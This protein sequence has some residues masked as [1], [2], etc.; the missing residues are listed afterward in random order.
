MNHIFAL[1]PR[2]R[3]DFQKSPTRFGEV[4]LSITGNLSKVGLFSYL[5]EL[6]G[7]SIAG[8][9]LGWQTIAIENVFAKY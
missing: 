1:C 7:V 9:A 2:C 5:Q 6:F 8:I 4:N 3:V